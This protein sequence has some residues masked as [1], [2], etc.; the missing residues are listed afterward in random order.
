[1]SMDFVELWD[2]IAFFKSHGYGVCDA[3]HYIEAV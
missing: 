2:L 3:I 1:M